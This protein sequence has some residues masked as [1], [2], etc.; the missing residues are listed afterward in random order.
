MNKILSAIRLDQLSFKKKKKS[1]AT[2]S[3]ETVSLHK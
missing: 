3:A 1:P 2:L